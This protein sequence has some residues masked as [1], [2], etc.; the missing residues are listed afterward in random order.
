[1]ANV[2]IITEKTDSARYYL[3]KVTVLQEMA[4]DYYRLWQTLFEI[5]GNKDSALFYAKRVTA[6]TDSLYKR[7]LDVS[8]AG[9]EK[10]YKYQGLQLENKNL[11]IKGKQNIFLLLTALFVLSLGIIIN[12]T[13]RNRT[14]NHQLKVQQQLL[15][16]E[17]DLIDKEKENNLLLERQVKMQNILLSN[18]EQYRTHS[19]K[20]SA[21]SQQGSL[22]ISPVLNLTF[23]EELIASIDIQYHDISKRLSER[24]PELTERDILICCLLLAD[25]DTGMIATILCVKLDSITTQ[26]HRL[27]TKLGMKKTDKLLD[28]LRCF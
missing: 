10:K 16:Q 25:F 22:V 4:P 24:F 7:K 27:R 11:T 28:Y 17:K 20:R 26:R 3:R 9:L 2:F 21:S 23:H 8:F 19:V 13:I 12:L 5:E 6:A 14:K 15:K 18:V 1:L